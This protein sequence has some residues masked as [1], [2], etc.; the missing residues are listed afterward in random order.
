MC[1]SHR[2]VCDIARV[3]HMLQVHWGQEA[4]LAGHGNPAGTWNTVSVQKCISSFKALIFKRS[5]FLNDINDENL[6]VTKG[7]EEKVNLQ[8]P[9]S[10]P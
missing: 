6:K 4:F 3:Y 8:S 7:I 10:L 5:T 2:S 1:V 9:G